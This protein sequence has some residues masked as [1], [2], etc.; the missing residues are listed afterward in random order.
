MLASVHNQTTIATWALAIHCALKDQGLDADQVFFDVGLDVAT[1]RDPNGRY[2]VVGMTALW[3]KAISLSNN[4]SFALTVPMFV[5][6]GT[7]HGLGLAA[8]S[9]QSLSDACTRL[10]RF[11][12]IVSDAANV[13]AFTDEKTARIEL[14]P[15][16]SAANAAYEA[17]AATIIQLTR[18]ITQR[19][20]LAPV[21]VELCSPEPENAA[22]Y[23]SFFG[24]T[25]K[26]GAKR[27]ALHLSRDIFEQPLPAA[28]SML[29]TANDQ[30]VQDYLK[31]YDDDI[32]R[33]T[34]HAI[35][36]RLAS[37]VPL[38]DEIAK[39]L[40]VSAR[41]LQRQLSDTGVSFSEIREEVQREMAELWLIQSDRS[42]AEITFRLGFSDQS[43]FSKAFKR[44]T[45]FPPAQY[46]QT[47][48]SKK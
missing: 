20:N 48:S 17:F 46:R 37:G 21:M 18:L 43:N 12:H 8:A 36:E 25:V 26:F 13:K 10:E 32:S 24:C 31:R 1:M 40:N 38:L 47:F 5:Q 33:L 34:R 15:I 4:P 39:R 30:V 22:T 28:N 29:A 3:D 11:S 2:P 42:V 23:H 27:W 41:N 16:C 44:W 9:S 19:S 14:Q 45:G 7:M 6:P 35:V